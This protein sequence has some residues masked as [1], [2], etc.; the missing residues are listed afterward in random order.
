V[1]LCI[2]RNFLK[3]Q[4]GF[5]FADSVAGYLQFRALSVFQSNNHAATEPRIHFIHVI[6][7]QKS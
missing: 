1:N 4:A 2:I 6:E 7:I 5:Q 3:I